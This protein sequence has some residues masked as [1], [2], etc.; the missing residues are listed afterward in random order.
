[1]AWVLRRR[2]LLI[3]LRVDIL[4]ATAALAR[5]TFASVPPYALFNTFA[6]RHTTGTI[7]LGFPSVD[8]RAYI[9]F[10]EVPAWIST[11]VFWSLLF[12]GITCHFISLAVPTYNVD[13]VSR[14]WE[15]CL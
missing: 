15:S 14:I 3:L 8:G 6:C 13:V 9:H 4:V 2:L 12:I 10:Y 5:F 11:A 1:M 7:C